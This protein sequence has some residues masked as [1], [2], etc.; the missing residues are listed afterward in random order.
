MVAVHAADQQAILLAFY[1][2]MGGPSWTN[3]EGWNS[4]FPYC[5]TSSQGMSWL[6]VACDN[7]GNVI[8]L[9]LEANNVASTTGLPTS[10]FQLTSLIKYESGK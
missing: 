3:S 10:L 5:N 7:D 8:E 1:N 6:G 9:L 2:A 4:G